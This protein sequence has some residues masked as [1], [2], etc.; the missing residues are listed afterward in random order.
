M[1]K[2]L[3]VLGVIVGLYLLYYIATNLFSNFNLKKE[4]KELNAKIK[5]L[6]FID[7]SL[8]KVS[9]KLETDYKVL[10]QTFVKDSVMLDSL[11]DEYSSSREI[12]KETETK[13][14]YYKGRYDDAKNKITY[15]ESHM[16]FIKG[17]TLLISLSKKIN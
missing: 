6:E 14:N 2:L 8:S 17:D 1:K 11:E 9:N 3:M 12:A 5:R 13:A 15:L 4:E 10:E 7:D 16:L